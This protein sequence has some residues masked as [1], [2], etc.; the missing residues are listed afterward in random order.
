LSE[1]QNGLGWTAG[2]GLEVG[3]APRWTVKAEYLH[4]DLSAQNYTLTGLSHEITSNVLR[5][6]ANYR[7]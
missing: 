6:G 1:T 4:V 7:F 5:F 3:L 2:G